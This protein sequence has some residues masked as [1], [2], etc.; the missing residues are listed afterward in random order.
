MSQWASAF[1]E[2]GLHVSKTLGD[3]T[4]PCLFAIMMGV[5]RVLHAKYSDH[6]PLTRIM[7][8]CAVLCVVGYLL[9]GLAGA[10]F[11]SLIGLRNGRLCGR[12]IL[13]WHIQPGC[14]QPASGGHCDVCAAG[15]SRRFG[16]CFGACCCWLCCGVGR[17]ATARRGVGC[18][19]ISVAVADWALA[20][21]Q[22][23]CE[24]GCWRG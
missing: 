15:V 22:S 17:W 6:M 7:A 19:R 12:R 5:A 23:T 2:S 9:A 21:R 4:G 14:G 20:Q 24:Q 1:A 8:A 3:L 16:L 11:I 18:D 13:A 10:P